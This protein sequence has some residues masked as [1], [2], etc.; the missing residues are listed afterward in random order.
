MA[1]IKT[2]KLD[3]ARRQIETAIRML[4][5]GEDPVAIHTLA[6][7]GLKLLQDLAKQTNTDSLFS[8]IIKPGKE[9]EVWAIIRRAYNFLKH[10]DS[11]PHAVIE[12]VKEEAND[13]LLFIACNYYRD[14]TQQPTATMLC[15]VSWY[16]A[17]HP[18]HTLLEPLVMTTELR[19][20]RGKNRCI[21]L[22]VGKELLNTAL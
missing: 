22:Q 9:K 11:D 2:T 4:F 6:S 7:A 5:S 17:F 13:V 12:G 18:D 16:A 15:F 10:A 21:H 1:E 19:E 14:L 8:S 3:A 20:L